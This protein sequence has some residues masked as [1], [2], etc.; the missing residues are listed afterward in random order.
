VIRQIDSNEAAQATQATTARSVGPTTPAAKSFQSVLAREKAAPADRTQVDKLPITAPQ[1]EVW[2]PVRGDD[3]YAK[4]VDG[5]RAG[6]YVNLSRGER[7]GEVFRVEEREGKRVHIYGEGDSQKVVDA[8]K[9]SGKV[10]AE[11]H[12]AQTAARHVPKNE[13]WAPVKGANNYADILNGPRNGLYVNTSGGERDGMAF[14]IVRRGDETYH[15]YGKGKHR[16]VVEVT[17]APKKADET[18]QTDAGNGGTKATETESSSSAS[19][20]TG[21][22]GASPAS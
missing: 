2:R 15:V 22:G 14:Q 6:M 19:R 17:S 1:G 9:D 11:K 10:R 4:I 7:R 5:P 12:D 16:Q 21:T 13:Q 20:T 8:A 18:A 3:N